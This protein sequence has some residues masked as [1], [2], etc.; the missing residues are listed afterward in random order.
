[1]KTIRWGI[2]GCG[3]VTEVK[4]GPG[5]QKAR[6]SA[7]A[8][9]MRR[10][11]ALAE[12]YARRHGVPKWYADA[13][14]LIRDP[15]VDAVYIA[16]PPASHREYVLACA[17]ASKPVY[18]EKPMALNYAECQE[19]IAACQAAG[20]PL[21][22]AYY[23]RA[24][25]R[26][27]KMKELVESG[28]I[29]QLRFVRVLLQKIATPAE[30]DPATRPWRVIPEISGGGHFLDMG[31][32]ML[33]YLDFV[34]GP[35]QRVHG[36][37]ANQAG[38]YPAEDA[39]TATF[40]F[41]SGIQGVGTWNAVS[42][43]DADQIEFV[44]GEGKLSFSCFGTEPIVLTTAAGVTHVAAETPA[45]VQQPLIQTVVDELNGI[46]VCPSTGVSAA[47]TTW[48]MDQVLGEYRGTAS[49]RSRPT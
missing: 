23:R 48:V 22:V 31:S 32:H 28:A 24:L 37:A 2:I 38:L 49:S 40:E 26:F 21:F 6:H 9:V 17:A 36:F 27:L 15:E 16:T 39:V 14:A 34:L 47:R 25:P 30:A 3:N 8:A 46:G 20:A 10:D 42:Y 35:I 44:G 43:G 13:E 12:D 11:A 4:S 19:M 7:L 5:F 29:G 41:A 33:D 45:H 18:V 1:M